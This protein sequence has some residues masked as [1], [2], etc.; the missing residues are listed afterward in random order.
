MPIGLC[1]N[2]KC[3]SCQI[4]VRHRNGYSSQYHAIAS[5]FTSIISGMPDAA[6]STLILF[7]VRW[8]CV[9][10]HTCICLRS[11]E[12]H[13][14]Y[15]SHFWPV[16]ETHEIL[17]YLWPKIRHQIGPKAI[18]QICS[19]STLMA[20]QFMGKSMCMKLIVFELWQSKPGDKLHSGCFYETHTYQPV[21][22][23]SML[24]HRSLWK[25]HTLPLK[26][27][28]FFH[29]KLHRVCWY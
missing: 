7:R 10:F 25:M 14:N 27:L 11:P 2:A 23:P 8:N 1:A 26:G 21:S 16:Y 19:R 24:I 4:W 18:M 6:T 22:V 20:L 15:K 13:D 5:Y 3:V 29:K 9:Q 28:H 12:V 17:Q